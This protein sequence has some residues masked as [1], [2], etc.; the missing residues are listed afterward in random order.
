MNS[1]QNKRKPCHV[2]FRFLCVMA[3][4]YMDKVGQVVLLNGLKFE[5]KEEN[6]TDFK[7]DNVK[8]F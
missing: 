5:L 3:Y 6:G 2:G 8:T 4:F 1:A 7:A